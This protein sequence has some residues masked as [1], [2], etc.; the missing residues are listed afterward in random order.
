MLLMRLLGLL[1][2][3][4]ES[5]QLHMTPYCTKRL[6]GLVRNGINRMKTTKTLEHPGYALQAERN[7]QGLIKYIEDYSHKVGTYPNLSDSQFDAA[8]RNAPSLWP[9]SAAG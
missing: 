9:Y 2:R 7:L 3:E 8:L 5:S 4:L 1:R 6:E